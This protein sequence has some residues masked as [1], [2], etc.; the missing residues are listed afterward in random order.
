ML[1]RIVAATVLTTS[2][3]LTAMGDA[4][5]DGR[6]GH[7]GYENPWNG[8]WGYEDSTYKN[9]RS[10]KANRTVVVDR[11]IHRRVENGTLPIRQLLNL[12]KSYKG[13]RVKSVAI[14]IRPDRSHG[15]VKLLVNNRTVDRERI[16]RENWITLRTDDDR[17]IGR[18]LR[19]LKLGVRGK[20]YIKDIQVTLA[21][22][23]YKRHT[24]VNHH[25]KAKNVPPKVTVIK[26]RHVEDPVVRILRVILKDMNTPGGVF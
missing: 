6:R 18:D 20:V 22:P 3:A 19:S 23:A 12:D 21:E 26:T 2:L 1:K 25:P 10:H 8:N 17:T 16:D 14:K 24:R 15:R 7:D 13:Y 11:K 9:K 5:A 4:A